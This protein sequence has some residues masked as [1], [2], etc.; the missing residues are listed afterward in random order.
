MLPFQHALE[1]LLIYN[2]AACIKH[3]LFFFSA[4]EILPMYIAVCIGTNCFSLVFIPHTYFE[5]KK[6]KKAPFSP[7]ELSKSVTLTASL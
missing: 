1:M 4:F 6:E 3:Q 2:I 5:K 7:F